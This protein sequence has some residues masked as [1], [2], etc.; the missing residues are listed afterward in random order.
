MHHEVKTKKGLASG[1]TLIELLVVI[2]I[3][4]IL[5]A[6]L[7]PALARAKYRARVTSCTS[8]YRQWGIVAAAYS[9][10]DAQSQLPS[11]NVDNP[12]GNPFDVS[13]N[14]AFGLVNYGL[15]APMWFCPVRP[16]FFNKR[17][18]DYTARV[19]HGIVT[20]ED[21]V[22]ACMWGATDT[23][24]GTRYCIMDATWWIPRYDRVN[25]A[26]SGQLYPYADPAPSYG[27][28]S[29]PNWPRKTTD[30]TAG[31]QPI[32]SDRCCSQNGSESRDKIRAVDHD[33]PNGANGHVFGG[34]VQSVNVAFADGHVES[35]NFQFLVWQY[36][37][38]VNNYWSFY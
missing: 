4:A 21:V 24:P 11:F 30:L 16:D 32:V 7:L 8:N 26:V 34:A 23:T 38:T 36:C 6:I 17:D 33:N 37:Q 10:D 12:G 35:R 29:G 2:A 25:G 28:A 5:A 13:T 27:A 22:A 31:I 15:S 14:M 20:I 9:A 3:I 19:G 18:S 1:F